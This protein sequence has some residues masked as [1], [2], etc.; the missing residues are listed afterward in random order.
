MKKI[1][2]KIYSNPFDQAKIKLTFFYVL[3][4]TLIIIIFSSIL[5]L[6]LE[7]NTRD[8]IEEVEVNQSIK[9]ELYSR[10]TDNLQNVIIVADLFILFLIAISSY[11]LAHKTLKPIKNSLDSQKKFTADASHD[12]RTPLAI[13]RTE[14]EVLIQNPNSSII[15]YKQVVKSNLEEISKMSNLVEDLLLV[16]R[17]ENISGISNLEKVDLKNLLNTLVTKNQKQVASKNLKLE[18]Q[19]E[20]S[21]Y[22]SINKYNFER[23]LQNILQNAINYTKENG[24]ISIKTKLTSKN[25]EIIIQDTGVGISGKDLPHIY[26]RFYKAEHSRNDN[27][28]SGL[29]LAITKQIIEQNGGNITLSSEIGVGTKVTITLQ[30]T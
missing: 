30:I 10:Q 28:G 22:L 15:D 11:Y 9:E 16:A 17:T 3:V 29:G 26:N 5:F 4:M 14:N 13:M 21:A 6:S 20:A 1:L 19:N 7:K 12:L 8:I 25:V 18:I 27:S 24:S 23:A 2:K